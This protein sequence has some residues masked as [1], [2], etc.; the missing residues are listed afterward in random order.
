MKLYE[1]VDLKDFDA[2]AG[3][4]QTLNTLIEKGDCELVEQY[5]MESFFENDYITATEVNDML[6]FEQDEIAH[7]LGYESWDDYENNTDED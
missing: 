2:W 3:A 4:V 6:R 7:W 5:L 1:E